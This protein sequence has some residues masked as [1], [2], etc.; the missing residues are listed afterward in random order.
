MCTDLFSY[1]LQNIGDAKNSSA[2][3]RRMHRK[4][5]VYCPSLD[6]GQTHFRT[7]RAITYGIKYGIAYAIICG[8]TLSTTRGAWPGTIPATAVPP[9]NVKWWQSD[10]YRSCAG[11]MTP[12]PAK[13]GYGH[14]YA[15]TYGL[16]T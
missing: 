3:R 8:I 12:L 9:F 6:I 16:P 15:I 4:N 13:P 5:A 14:L 11:Q 2:Y 1:L 7:K 10:I